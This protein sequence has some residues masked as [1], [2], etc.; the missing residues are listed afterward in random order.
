VFASS[1]ACQR[2]TDLEQ[3]AAAFGLRLAPGADAG[4]GELTVGQV[5]ATLGRLESLA[6]LY[7]RLLVYHRSTLGSDRCQPDEVYSQA[8]Y[9]EA[10][11]EQVGVE[12]PLR[13]W[14]TLPTP[15]LG[16]GMG[17]LF[18][19]DSGVGDRHLPFL[20]VDYY[21][22]TGEYPVCAHLIGAFELLRA[23]QLEVVE[24]DPDELQAFLAGLTVE[25]LL[26]EPALWRRLGRTFCQLTP[27]GDLLP[28]RVRH[29]TGWLMKVAPLTHPEPLPFLLADLAGSVLTTGPLPEIVSAVSLRT[30]P[31]RRQRLNRLT[32]PSGR[33]FDPRHD[34]LFLCLAEERLRLEQRHDLPARERKRQANVLKLALN[35]ACFGLL[36]QVNVR[37]LGKPIVVE[38]V[39]LDGSGG[40][41][42]VDVLEEPGRWY[43][44]PLAA[45]VTAAG[46]LLLRL[47]RLL[48]E[49]AGGRVSYWDT[50]SVCVS[51]L[52]DKQMAEIQ[53]RLERLSPYAPELRRSPGEPMLLALEPENRDDGGARRQL[54]LDATASKSYVLYT[55]RSSAG[56][57]PEGLQPVKVSEHGLGHLRPPTD[58]PDWIETGKSYLLE[59]AL[60]LPATEPSWSDVPALSVISLTRPAELERLEHAFAAG[61]TN[62]LRPFSRLAVLHPI[63]QYARVEDGARRTPVA[64]YHD[65][66]DWRTATWRDL[67]SGEPLHPRLPGQKLTE[68]DLH[69]QPGRVL[70]DTLGSKLEH[71]RR[72][73]EA[74]SLDADGNPCGPDTIGPLQPAHTDSHRHV[75]IGKETRNLDRAGITEDPTYTLYTDTNEQA[76][77]HTFLPVLRDLNA[78]AAYAGGFGGLTRL[79]HTIGV[80]RSTIVRARNGDA[81]RQT[82]ERLKPAL[83]GLARE[84]LR[85]LTPEYEPPDDPEQTCHLYLRARALHRPRRCHGCGAELTG[86]QQKWC[87]KCRNRPR[88]RRAAGDLTATGDAFGQPIPPR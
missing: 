37:H 10:I 41:A 84:A 52:T 26:S 76:W 2:L 30:I 69:A 11:L 71:D 73:R 36:C 63:P 31:R 48:V 17:A 57:E 45:A 64:P 50:D 25:R 80:S 44:P 18:G 27:R 38:L 20:P 53:Q 65:S 29:G 43:C 9:G 1:L 6:G 88:L 28:H 56:G 83:G 24:E 13:K 87:D 39:R 49:Q 72:R 23:T 82:R 60:N 12:L 42:R 68:G 32:L 5:E 7:T 55:V 22:V 35:A 59:R 58:D 47:I 66:F 67:T 40:T 86:R 3:A 77:Q 16:T 61:K 62:G 75:L 8:S 4:A 51:G 33:V 46:R 34:D 14:K 74:K 21:D 70:I 78:L 19:G 15:L 81:T 79:A 85:T 54:Y